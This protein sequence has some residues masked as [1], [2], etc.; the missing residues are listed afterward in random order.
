[1]E[2]LEGQ[3]KPYQKFIDSLNGSDQTREK[4]MQQ[5][6]YYIKYL[7]IKDPNTLITEDLTDSPKAVRKAEDKI[8]EY[9]KYL[10]NEEKLSYQ[11]INLRVAAILSF[12]SINRVNI[13]RKYVSKFKPAN[14][15]IRKNDKAYTHDQILSILNSQ[16]SLRN[17]TITLLLASTGMRA[18]ALHSLTIGS[19][20]KLQVNGYPDSYLYKI[21]VYEQDEENYYCFTTFECAAMIDQ[22][23]NFRQRSGEI[24]T[25][26]SPLLREE[27]NHMDRFAAARPKFIDYKSVYGIIARLLVVSGTRSHTKVHRYLH[28]VML[29]HGFRKFNITQMIKAKVDYSTREFLVGHKHSRGLDVN[30]DRTHE[31][32]RLQE[33]LKAMDLL[34]ISPENRLRKRVAEQKHT[35]QVQMAEKD[36]QIE[37]LI[38]RQDQLEAWLQNPEQFIKMRDEAFAMGQKKKKS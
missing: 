7:G 38:Q 16:V 36:R 17:K 34:T 30:Y 24:I 8:I 9:I 26:D 25:K 21:K 15:K 22:Y 27:F 1:L 29:S 32:D 37:Q 33:F 20:E 5:I 31:D 14:R 35:I 19:L 13:D 12:Y 10:Y 11:T 18:G 23:L 6:G 3:Q 2:V 4:Y 28:D